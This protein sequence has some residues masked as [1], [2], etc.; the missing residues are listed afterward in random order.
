MAY[1]AA[2]MN[3]KTQDFFGSLD[4]PVIG[5]YGMSEVAAASTVWDL[6]RCRAYTSG[7]AIKGIEFK[8]A[9]PDAEGVGEICMR[10][11]T[12]F[13]G[14]FKNAEATRQVYDAEGYVHSGDLGKMPDGILEITGRIKELIITA[15]GEN[16]PPVLIE[17]TFKEV[18]TIVSNVMVVG[19]NRR[20]L[21][22]IVTL[23]V[24]W[25][26]AKGVPLHTLSTE[27]KL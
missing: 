2:P 11:R 13:L 19:D 24:E 1:S 27:C 5:L 20:F 21:S 16:I 18:C 17:H 14:Y 9:D 4:M 15:G 8:I 25:D 6:K 22:A 23:K 12:S 7:V 3:K 10:G 26:Q